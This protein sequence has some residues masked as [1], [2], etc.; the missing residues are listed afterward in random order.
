[1]LLLVRASI[2]ERETMGFWAPSTATEAQL[3]KLVERGALPVLTP[4]RE[5]M[6]PPVDH[7]E[8]RPPEGYV[9]SLM[10]FHERG[11]GVPAEEFL[12]RLLF[13]WDVEI[14]HLTPNGVMLVAAFVTL[15]E[16]WLGIEPNWDLFKELF[17]VKIQ[18]KDKTPVPIGCAMIQ[19]RPK[20]KAKFPKIDP[21]SSISEWREGWFYL[22]NPVDRP[23]PAFTGKVFESGSM[24][25]RE[26]SDAHDRGL[27]KEAIGKIS[28]LGSA[29]LTTA[30]L[31]ACWLTKRVVPLRHRPLRLWEL[32]Q[33][34]APWPG[35]VVSRS[36]TE[37]EVRQK[38]REISGSSIPSGGFPLPLPLGAA[39]IKAVVS[40]HAFLRWFV[41]SFPVDSESFP[42]CADWRF[43][44]RGLSPSAARR[45]SIRGGGGGGGP[46]GRGRGR[47]GEFDG[48]Q[49]P[50]WSRDS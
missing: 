1:V 11:L 22:R 30:H 28:Q 45:S 10:A 34:K 9:V 50:P 26:W 24:P 3:R 2:R 49:R 13:R 25:W 36:L 5:W 15:C 47:R 23:F 4:A 43:C 38:A 19:F 17:F 32:T 7:V 39:Q 48:E 33:E 20:M 31:V 35:T 21:P 46:P 16:G 14:Q 44:A 37:A 40:A 6:A 27:V 8:P 12:R 41:S 18:D 29:G 42:L